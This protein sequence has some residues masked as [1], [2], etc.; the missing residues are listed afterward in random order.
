MYENPR[1]FFIRFLLVTVCT[2]VMVAISFGLLNAGTFGIILS[3]IIVAISAFLL[4]AMF[5]LALMN[6]IRYLFDKKQKKHFIMHFI[7][8]V[9]S[10]AIVSIFIL[11]YL[12]IMMGAFIVLAPFL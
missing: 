10:F 3:A 7:N 2:I 11:F 1:K 5:V 6:F 9:F 4:I 12:T 8:V